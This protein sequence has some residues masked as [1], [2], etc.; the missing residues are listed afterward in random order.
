MATPAS[1]VW[2]LG[3][4]LFHALAGQPPYEV[5][6]NLMGALYRI[7]HEEPPRL[8]DAGWLG[9]AA[10]EHDDQG[11]G[12]PLADGAGARLPRRRP[13]GGADARGPDAAPAPRP[14][15]REP[16]PA[17]RHR[18]PSHPADG[19]Q[20][21][22]PT[23]CPEPPPTAAPVHR[24][25]PG[26]AIIGVLAALVVVLLFLLFA[27]LFG[28]FDGQDADGLRHPR[29]RPVVVA[30]LG[31]HAVHEPVGSRGPGRGDAGASSPTTSPLAVDDPKTSWTMLTPEFQ[32]ASGGFGKLQEVLGPVVLGDPRQH[33]G[34]RRD[35]HGELRHHLRPRGRR[36]PGRR[37][38]PPARRGRR[39]IPDR[40]RAVVGPPRARF[41]RRSV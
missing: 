17:R 3:A 15:S 34:R 41:G 27:W 6:D 23:P 7:V 1:D 26:G 37:R 36:V 38:H 35:A 16:P 20:V 29:R 31:G 30:V 4:T 2:S 5:G 32:S 10:R 18:P 8:A 21:L 22:A 33:R 13:A 12:R 28:A 40:R 14:S 25:G 39:R 9:A 11:P 24:R 19:T